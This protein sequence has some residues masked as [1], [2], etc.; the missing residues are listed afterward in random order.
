MRAGPRV[1]HG[2][3][4]GQDLPRQA[5]AYVTALDKYM[6]SDTVGVGGYRWSNLM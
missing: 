6:Y 2:V 3:S 5:T 4:K 1:S